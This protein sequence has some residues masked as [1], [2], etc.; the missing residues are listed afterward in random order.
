MPSSQRFLARNRMLSHT[1][2][3]EVSQVAIVGDI[4]QSSSNRV[5]AV[6]DRQEFVKKVCTQTDE[7]VQFMRLG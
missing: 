5:A 2:C 1:V 4:G 3:V 7:G 6:E